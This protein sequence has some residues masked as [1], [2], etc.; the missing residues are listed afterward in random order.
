MSLLQTLNECIFSH[1]KSWDD[2]I[3]IGCA[4]F[5]IP[6]DNFIKLAGNTLEEYSSEIPEDLI[7]VGKDFWIERFSDGEFCDHWEYKAYPKKPRR[8]ETIKTLTCRELS[9]EEYECMKKEHHNRLQGTK[10]SPFFIDSNKAEMW[11]LLYKR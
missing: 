1:N 9:E 10:V 2:V 4:E 3:W 5:T 6:I 7:V 11:M 8:I